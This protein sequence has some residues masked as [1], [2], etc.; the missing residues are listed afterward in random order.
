[1]PELGPYGS[2]RGARGEL[3]SLPRKWLADSQ[4]DAFDPLA[5]TKSAT[6]TIWVSKSATTT[7]KRQQYE[8]LEELAAH[9]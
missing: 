4:S 6:Q 1:M 8:N 2:V 9:A 7:Q 5:D 3:A